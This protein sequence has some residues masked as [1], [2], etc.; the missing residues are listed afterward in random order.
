MKLLNF[1][2]S[3]VDNLRRVIGVKIK[4]LR[5]ASGMS[6]ADLAELVACDAPVISRY[7]LGKTL[8]NIEHLIR[9]STALNVSPAEL[10]PSGQDS[11]RAQLIALR[12][13]LYEKSLQ[14]ESVEY[15]EK[16]IKFADDYIESNTSK[17]V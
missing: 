15:L 16:L 3:P 2:G 8:P 7:E 1:L 12:Q 14:V 9:I 4:A 10:L 5:R 6:Q 17:K 11:L 13:D